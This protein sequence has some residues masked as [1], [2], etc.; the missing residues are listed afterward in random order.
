MVRAPT[1]RSE[2]TTA[3]RLGGLVKSC[4]DIMRKDKGLNGELDRLPQLTWMLFLKFL[5]DLEREDE[6]R[7]ALAGKGHSGIIPPGYRWRDWAADATGITGEDLI[8]FISAEEYDKADGTRAPGLLATLRDLTAAGDADRGAV[9]RRVFRGVSNR[10]Q[11]GYL[12]RD[13][14]NKLDGIHFTSQDEV[15]TLSAI[16]EGMLREMR[17]AAGD[18]GEF[19]TPRPLVALMVALTDPQLGETLLDPAAGTGGFLVEAFE[20]LRRLVTTDAQRKAL[21]T[22]ALYGNEPKS[23]PLMLCEMNLLLHGVHVPN[24]SD[25]NSLAV[26]LAEIGDNERVDIVLTNPPFGGEEEVS[27]KSN[28][29]ADKQ[30][31]ETALL[32][33]QVIMR[34]LRRPGHLGRQGGRAG[35]VVPNGTLFADGVAARIKEQLVKDFR[36]HTIVRLPKGVFAPYT[37]IQTNVLFFDHAGP[38]DDIWFY[39]HL[40]PAGRKNYSK[41]KPLKFEEFGP[42]VE[43]WSERSENERAWKVAVADVLRYDTAG[44]VVACDL[45]Q[46]SPNSDEELELRPLND[47]V[48]ELL[49]SEEEILKLVQSLKSPAE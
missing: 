15:H 27:I 21:Q 42:L 8:L 14:V 26:R 49:T 44:R 38:T 2:Q 32:F 13:V 19:Y 39:E 46:K 25:H 4:R 37:D 30:T 5:D 6:T 18:S 36:L 34:R 40:P 22:E 33:L 31:A 11:N 7:A 41:T 23:L 24:I 29:P 48:D 45:D 9:V 1:T 17:D 35:V 47:I 28:F 20:H 43:W 16:Y 10:M 3:Q 12:M